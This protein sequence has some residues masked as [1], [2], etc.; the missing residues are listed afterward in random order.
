MADLEG[1]SGGLVRHLSLAEVAEGIHGDLRV[2]LS[3]VTGF[4]RSAHRAADVVGVKAGTRVRRVVEVRTVVAVAKKLFA[5]V[6]RG[7]WRAGEPVGRKSGRGRGRVDR[8]LHRSRGGRRPDRLA[9]WVPMS[10]D[11]VRAGLRRCH[12]GEP[13]SPEGA[14]GR[15]GMR[16]RTTRRTAALAAVALVGVEAVVVGRRRGSLWSIET[17]V[18]CRD[19][20]L[21]T[22][23]WIPGASLKA[24]RLGWW[25]FQRCPVGL[26]WSLVTPAWVA[27]LS[28]DERR[29]A[30]QHH[31]ARIP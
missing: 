4:A 30:G 11:R 1:D 19:G 17:V 23:W 24:L 18:R 5:A 2:P 29:S 9:T 6:H 28:D 10:P 12:G 3:A 7:M 15:V 25:R 13:R 14:G 27:R 26:H 21:Y 31:D 22:T 20:H 16:S 8:G